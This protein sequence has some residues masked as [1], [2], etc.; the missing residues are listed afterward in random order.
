MANSALHAITMEQVRIS[1]P[2]FYDE[3]LKVVEGITELLRKLSDKHSEFRPYISFTETYDR[4]SNEPILQ[5]VVTGY[6][7]EFRLHI[8][9]PKDNKFIIGLTG[10]GIVAGNADDTLSAIQGEIDKTSWL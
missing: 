2:S 6:N 8:Y 5:L 9:I 4:A 10:S 7:K 1:D 3:Y